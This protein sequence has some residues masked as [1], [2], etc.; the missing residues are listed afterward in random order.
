MSAEAQSYLERVV[1]A[2][3]RLKSLI[4]DLLTLSRI[5]RGARGRGLV[6]MN[7]VMQE[8]RQEI[9]LTLQLGQARLV[10][11]AELPRVSYDRTEL[12]MVFRNL[13]S[14]GLKFNRNPEP[15]V[16]I[17]VEEGKAFVTVAVRDNGIGIA[18]GDQGQVFVMFRRLNSAADFPG[19][20][21][22]LT[23]VKRIVER[24]GGRIWL[25]STEGEGSTFFFTIPREG[26]RH[27]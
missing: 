4:D 16:E 6:A 12:T 27:G 1:Q 21:A 11:P 17:S 9:D 26:G 22:G 14:N 5:G 7:G 18:S 15:C 25:E 24:H 8:I 20:G 3:G 13:V 23:I 19:T 2:S 10:F